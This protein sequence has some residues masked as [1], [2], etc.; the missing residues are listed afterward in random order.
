MNFKKVISIIIEDLEFHAGKSWF[1]KVLVFFFNMPFRLVL[2]Y[3]LG[4]FFL[5]RRNPI[6]HFFIL[7]L[8]KSQ[9]LKR[10]CD[11]SYNANIGR[12]VKF[13]HP[14]SIVIGERVTIGDDV[15]IWHEVTL[16]SHGKSDLKTN[17]PI[18]GNNVKF[19][20]GC[21]I[22][23]GIKIGD[24]VKVGAN[25]VVLNDVKNGKVVVGIPASE[26]I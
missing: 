25:A 8:K 4:N 3:R 23:G 21:K 10:N 9:I 1:R 26:K 13:P 16:G 19:Y 2:N 12:R 11:I 22:L 20:T 18:I 5:K 15:M 24:F 6:F 14:L 17:Y 7:L